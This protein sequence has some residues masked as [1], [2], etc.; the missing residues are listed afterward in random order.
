MSELIVAIDGGGTKCNATIYDFSGQAL[1]SATSGSA[2]VF[3]DFKQACH[4]IIDAST[5]CINQ[6]NLRSSYDLRD[7]VLSAGCAGAGIEESTKAFAEWQSPFRHKILTSDLHISALSANN[8]ENCSLV[9]L[10]TGSSFAVLREGEC[11]QY[12]GHGFLLGDEASGAHLGKRALQVCLAYFD[13]TGGNTH[14]SNNDSILVND[15]T[16]FVHQITQTHDVKSSA[17][18]VQ[19]YAKAAPARFA[20]ITPLIFALANQ[21][22][23]VA[24]SLIDE[25]CE[26]ILTMLQS[27]R[28]DASEPCFV[29]GGLSSSYLPYLR[30]KS[31]LP[32]LTSSNPAEYGAYLYAYKNLKESHNAYG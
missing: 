20:E 2:N 18:I 13:A 8:G 25:A 26:Y 19:R 30:S 31:D 10:G 1:A 6:L 4:S 11:R 27:K 16:E 14:S 9:I 7:L 29:V 22:N 24:L 12:G 15:T 32:L 28:S 17:Q 21:Q 23:K 3:S 5:Q